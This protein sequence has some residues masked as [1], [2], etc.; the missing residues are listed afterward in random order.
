MQGDPDLRIGVALFYFQLL[1]GKKFIHV[2]GGFILIMKYPVYMKFRSK[3]VFL[4]FSLFF[5]GNNSFAQQAISF[6][7]KTISIT[8]TIQELVLVSRFISY[9]NFLFEFKM[10]KWDSVEVFTESKIINSKSFEDT[11]GVYLLNPISR[12]YVEFDSLHPNAKL[13]KRG[14]IS[15]KEFGFRYRDTATDYFAPY[16]SEELKDTVL[17]NQQL[18]YIPFEINDKNEKYHS[19]I[20]FSKDPSLNSPFDYVYSKFSKPKLSMVGFTLFFEDKNQKLEL[21]FE[22]VKELDKSWQ[23]ICKKLIEKAGFL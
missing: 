13:V 15:E 17:W 9:G 5:L 3:F 16:A 7:Q 6:E 10:A 12:T 19:T 11:V 23:N 2:L 20:F 14:K 8:D 1:A 4:I 22:N 21:R 18:L